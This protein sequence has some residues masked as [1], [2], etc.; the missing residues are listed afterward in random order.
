MLSKWFGLGRK[1]RHSLRRPAPA[2]KSGR[3]AVQLAVEHLETREV[4][5][6]SFRPQFGAESVVKN[7]GN[8]LSSP[9]VYLLFEGSYWQ[10][11]GSGL[12]TAIQNAMRT[13]LD[14][15]YLSGLK[16]YGSDGHATYGNAAIDGSGLS[17]NFSDGEL[18]DKLQGILLDHNGPFV[19]PNTPAHPPVY[20][21]ITPPGIKSNDPK[22]TSYHRADWWFDPSFSL[23]VPY[24]AWIGGPSSDAGSFQSKL[25]LYTQHISHELVETMS[26]PRT[27]DIVVPVLNIVLSGTGVHVSHGA[28]WTGGGDDEIAD[29]EPDSG[30]SARINGVLVEPYW[31][32]QD[33]AYVIPDGASDQVK[34]LPQWNGTTFTKQYLLSIPGGDV[35]L[36][37]MA[38]GGLS[39]THNGSAAVSFDAGKLQKAWVISQ[40]ASNTIRID[41]T[42]DNV[43]LTI[44][45]GTG[46]STID[47]RGTGANAP[48]TVLGDQ[49]N[50]TVAVRANSSPVSIDGGGGTDSV[51]VGTQADGSGSMNAIGAKVTVS[52]VSYLTVDDSSS[53]AKRSATIT[54]TTVNGL[55]GAPVFYSGV[56]A[57]LSVKGGTGDNTFDILSTPDWLNVNVTG[58]IGNDTFY[59]RSTGYGSTLDVQGG[60]GFGFDSVIVGYRGAGVAGSMSAIGG[61]VN[62]SNVSNLTVDASG[63]PYHPYTDDGK[64][65][66]GL[67][68]FAV[69]YSGISGS[70]TVKTGH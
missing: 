19:R 24:E 63:D 41:G 47:I 14:S 31:S 44:Y 68:P 57:S 4:P 3:N 23:Q 60:G 26:D 27:T 40:N 17:Q 7:G 36:A 65:I 9:P 54:S 42:M 32:Q 61:T 28:S 38:T 34:A 18:K 13:L 50:E 53:F 52:N 10:N 6:V 69:L 21:V 37:R 1:S 11:Q 70:K 35:D 58:G 46:P 64:S 15:P 22:D 33:Q 43:P 20:M 39:V 16:Q 29:A 25:D 55:G 8:V 66:A 12:A 48:I 56:L 49:G 45:C 62:V 67:S 51:T 30:Y 5:T 59:V 2:R